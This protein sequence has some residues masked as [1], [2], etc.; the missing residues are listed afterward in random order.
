[1]LKIPNTCLVDK[2]ILKNKIYAHEIKNDIVEK[3]TWMYKLSPNTLKNINKSNI[4]EIQI[5]EIELKEKRL[6]TNILKIIIKKIPYPIL[7][8]LK[9]NDNFCYAT[10]KDYIQC[11]NWNEDIELSIEG[12]NLEEIYQNFIESILK[13]NEYE[14]TFNKMLKEHI[15]FTIEEPEIEEQSKHGLNEIIKPEIDKLFDTESKENDFN[16]HINHRENSIF[17][18]L[19][20][21][22]M[23]IFKYSNED[24]QK[25]KTSLINIAKSTIITQIEDRILNFITKVLDELEEKNYSLEKINELYLKDYKYTAF[26][27]KCLNCV[28]NEVNE[29]KIN[30]YKNIF[31]KGI[32]GRI[33][34]I[35]N[36]NKILIIVSE[37]NY[38]EILY[39][40]YFYYLSKNSENEIL[41]I[42][43]KICN[44]LVISYKDIDKN[45]FKDF[46]VNNLKNEGL[47]EEKSE[48]IDLYSKPIITYELTKY[49]KILL[50]K[51][52]LI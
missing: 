33:N 6:P 8:V 41:R 23:N 15:D 52:G 35:L 43:Q 50:E 17:T 48:L 32:T 1:M 36:L 24:N 40:Q 44:F 16:N 42:K 20:E 28:L 27:Y 22:N 11:S 51:I 47:I 5:L 39:L 9:N 25:L 7:F 10:S 2:Q 12:S 49:G 30:I 19:M 18:N 29:E 38:E 13:K 45:P 3:I 37:M 46:T 21:T 31:I 4:E 14:I 26:T 34:E